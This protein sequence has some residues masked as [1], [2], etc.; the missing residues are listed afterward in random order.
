MARVDVLPI[1]REDLDTV[2]VFLH[3]HLNSRLSASEWAQAVQVPWDIE[4]PNHGYMLVEGGS[5]V[6]VY[7]AF[8]SERQLA[9]RLERFCNLGAWCVLPKHRFHSLLLLRALLAQKGYHFTDFSPSGNTVP[10]NERL[11]FQ[12]LDTSSALMLN[13]P[14]PSIARN[15]RVISDHLLIEQ[16]LNL[17]ELKMFQDHLGA[18]AVRHAVIIVGDKHC[19]V[20]FRKDRRK[21]LALFASVLYVSDPTIFRRGIRQFARHLLLRHRVVATLMELRVIGERPQG[22]IMLNQARPKMFKSESLQCD[23]IDYLYSELVCV[24]W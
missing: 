5:T 1:R 12:R 20:A 19:Y 2:G 18:K 24:A 10:V 22:C 9:G 16:T 6:G 7:L 14:W 23:Q 21:S 11:G 4:T 15:V 13:L 17:H 3:F 8:Y